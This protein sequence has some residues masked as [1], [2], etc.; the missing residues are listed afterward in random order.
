MNSHEA[1]LIY[2][3]PLPNG[4]ARL[5]LDLFPS[6]PSSYGAQHDAFVA[7]FRLLETREV[8]GLVSLRA[9][10]KL[11]ELLAFLG[12]SWEEARLRWPELAAM[13]AYRQEHGKDAYASLDQWEQFFQLLG[14]GI[15][16][17]R[18]EVASIEEC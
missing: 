13:A 17:E 18:V 7:R 5:H 11:P 6:I 3:R 8:S 14:D 1:T 16:P 12:G 9:E 15:L 4:R 2:A 10:A